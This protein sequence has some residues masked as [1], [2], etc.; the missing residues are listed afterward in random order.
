MPRLNQ[1]RFD[2]VKL[3]PFWAGHIDHY[4]ALLFIRSDHLY[5]CLLAHRENWM[6]WRNDVVIIDAQ[7]N[8]TRLDTS[9]RR[10]STG[11][12]ILKDPSLAV[13]CLIF[14][15]RCAECCTTRCPPSTAM[16]ES[17]MRRLQLLQEIADFLLKI[18]WRIR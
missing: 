10:R 6:V 9:R 8:I 3:F 16:E 4:P 7:E 12:H 2:K 15:V 5:A 17:E 18:G 1:L 11:M 14:Q 13:L